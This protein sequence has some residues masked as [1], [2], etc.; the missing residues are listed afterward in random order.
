MKFALAEKDGYT[1]RFYREQLGLT[2]K[3]AAER[4]GVHPS[5]ISRLERRQAVPVGRLEALGL[6]L[7]ILDRDGSEHTPT[8]FM[9]VLHER[10][11]EMDDDELFDF[12]I[13]T[14]LVSKEKLEELATKLG[15]KL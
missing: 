11:E 12:A 5:T 1:F 2:R 13:S 4:L 14:G 7:T 8:S 15:L 3:Q 6:R 10:M 9:S